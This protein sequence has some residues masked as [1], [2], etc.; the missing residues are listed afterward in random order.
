MKRISAVLILSLGFVIFCGAQTQAVNGE[1]NFYQE[2]IASWYGTEFDGRPTASGELFNSTLFTAAHPTLPFG[3]MLRVTNKHNNRQVTVRVNDRGPFVSARIIDLSQAAAE[4]L[5]LIATGTAPVI[6]E[7]EENTLSRG[8]SFLQGNSIPGGAA[9]DQAPRQVPV[10]K[11]DSIDGYPVI[12]SLDEK[13]AAS[14]PAQREQRT[15][16]AAQT[17][18]QTQLLPPMI[19]MSQEQ[20]PA[21]QAP[22]RKAAETPPAGS[23]YYSPPGNPQA[24]GPGQPQLVPAPAVPPVSQ[25]VQPPAE[26]QVPAIQSKQNIPPPASAPR[27]APVMPKP[28][29]LPPAE[30]KGSSPQTGKVYRV[31]VGAFKVAR[32][33]VDAFD[34]LKTT[35]LNP[36]YERNGDLYRVVL[37][38]VQSEELRSIAEKLGAAGFREA[39][40]RE[41]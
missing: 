10:A 41:E 27:N 24:P 11:V 26:F 13:A 6:V 18:P 39:L 19:Q 9:M 3:S 34:K 40:L 35:G 38:G 12:Q 8:G 29:N 23:Q 32:N 30:I 2:G 16:A 1:G 21:V 31:Q 7:R 14:T 20:A 28:G 25:P 33:A 15:L 5:D 37:S 4:A 36:A 17:T 22:P